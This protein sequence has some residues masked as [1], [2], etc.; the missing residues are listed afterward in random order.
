MSSPTANNGHATHSLP[1][2]TAAGRILA[3]STEDWPY[4]AWQSLSGPTPPRMRPP[5]A[6]DG[7]T[8]PTAFAKNL[9]SPRWFW[10]ILFEPPAYHLRGHASQ[11]STNLAIKRCRTTPLSPD[12]QVNRPPPPCDINA[13]STYRLA[14]RRL[15]LCWGSH[16]PRLSAPLLAQPPTATDRWAPACTQVVCHFVWTEI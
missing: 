14:S 16:P 1:I 2:S 8:H 9:A 10:Q 12:R 5:V 7:R 3:K 4:A 11:E 13:P 6:W 15:R